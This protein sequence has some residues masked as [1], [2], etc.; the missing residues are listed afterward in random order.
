[1][2]LGLVML[3]TFAFFSIHAVWRHERFG[4]F[5]HDLGIW[6]QSV[7][8]LAKGEMFNTVRGLDVFA[9][10]VSPGLFF[11]TPLY[12]LGA[13]PNFLNIFMIAVVVL[14]GIPVFRA[15]RHY[16]TNEWH[17]VVP[18]V[19]FVINYAGQ[20]M[21]HETFHPE[22]VAI[23][24][25]LF[26][27]TAAIEKRWTPFALWL[28]VAIA[29]KEDLAL[30]G[31]MLGFL[32]LVRRERMVGLATMA[33]CAGWF[34]FA[35]QVIVPWLSP[36][37]GFTE[38]LFGDLGASAPEIARNSV[39]DPG[40]VWDHLSTADVLGY[41]RDLLAS[42]GFV[43]LLSPLALLIGLP[44]ALINL[45][46]VHN[47]FWTTRVHYAAIPLAAVTIATVEGLAR[48]RRLG[49][50]RFLLGAV[51]V[52][53]LGTAIG[54]GV[55]VFSPTYR[56]GFWPLEESP[57]QQQY[58]ASLDIPPADA[59]VS[60]S[61]SLVPHL[62]H[63][64]QVYTFPNPWRDQNWGVIGEGQHDPSAVDWIILDTS[65][66][67]AEDC[68]LLNDIVDGLYEG[69]WEIVSGEIACGSPVQSAVEDP[70]VVV[71]QVRE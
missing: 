38:Q 42:F 40:L 1:V 57:H 27:Y 17:A 16:L 18:A 62:S 58:E 25:F 4:T 28:A 12:W 50:R 48:P 33:L 15:A 9:F 24:P 47:F 10:H 53:S 20:W 71:R 23:T 39:G 21:M 30:A 70:V 34:I 60:S 67:N 6:D 37:G 44:Q 68:T 65:L 32:L 55:T 11:L 5:D 56:E 22:V 64:S 2:V 36:Q 3:T 29:W 43:P 46:A 66:L 45:L 69:D 8:L 13:G 49:W 61:Y 35:T 54:W 52:G 51:A 7:W 41:F 19:A 63:R 31:V 59:S 14:G 26:G